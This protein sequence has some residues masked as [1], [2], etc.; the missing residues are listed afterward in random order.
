MGPGEV[1]LR[2][3][4]WDLLPEGIA[5]DERRGVFYLSSVSGRNILRVTADGDVEDFIET[6]EEGFPCGLGLTLIG[7]DGLYQYEGSLLAIQ[8]ALGLDR[9]VR[10]KL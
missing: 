5:H 9:V 10:L 8:N 6:E 4:R 1:G 7:V 3:E 2:I